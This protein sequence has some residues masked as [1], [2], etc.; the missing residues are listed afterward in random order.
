[1]KEVVFTKDFATKKAGD[2]FLC[3]STL[4]S[5]LVKKGVAKYA[6][7]EAVTV[8]KVSKKR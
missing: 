1:M 2:K 4:A 6:T 5:D 7:D 3:S 8:E